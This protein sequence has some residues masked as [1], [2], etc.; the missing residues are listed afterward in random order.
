MPDFR[1]T[2]QCGR[3]AVTFTTAGPDAVQVRACQCSFCRRHGA[4]TV[5]DPAGKIEFSAERGAISRHVFGMR[6]AEFMFC[7]T[8]GV[9][10]GV[11][12]RIDGADYACVNAVGVDYAEFAGRPAVK[13]NLDQETRPE[14][15][16]RRKNNWSP[17]R[18]IETV[19]VGAA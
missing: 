11:V 4:H 5:T 3:V 7:S 10:L 8:C 1:G 14:R 13:V 16:A 12:A 18:V 17:A 19:P 2:C 6:S 15:D 9:Y